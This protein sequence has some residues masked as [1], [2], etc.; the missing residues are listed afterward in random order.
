MHCGK[1]VYSVLIS[2]SY[3]EACLT[4]EAVTQEINKYIL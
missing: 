4:G 3:D 1:L 2:R